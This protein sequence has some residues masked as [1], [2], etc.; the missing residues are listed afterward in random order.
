MG[1]LPHRSRSWFTV[2]VIAL[3]VSGVSRLSPGAA[4]GAVPTAAEQSEARISLAEHLADL[5]SQTVRSGGL[6]E[7]AFRE[8][9]VLLEAAGRVNPQEPRYPRLQASA[10]AQL[11]DLDG[12][13]G[14]WLAYRKLVPDDR[15]AQQ[16]LIDLYAAKI[17]TADGKLA[18]LRALLDK[19]QVPEEVRAHVGA[20]CVALLTDRSKDE[21]IEMTARAKKLYPLPEVL[22]WEYELVGKQAA[23][24]AR[25]HSLLALL[26]ANP[27]QPQRVAEL[28]HILASNGL[29]RESLDWYATALNLDNRIARAPSHNLAVEC[30]AELYI[31][32]ETQAAAS[33]VGRLLQVQPDDPDF[34]F[35]KLTLDRGAGQQVALSQNLGLAKDAFVRRLAVVNDQIL[36][37]NAGAATQAGV[38]DA[39]DPSAAIESLKAH[40]RPE[41]HDAF[42]WALDNLAWFEVYYDQQPDAATPWIKALKALLP[43]EDVT[44]RRV[45][46]WQ[47]LAAGR[48]AEARAAL[49]PVAEHDPLAAL[50]IIRLNKDI[51]DEAELEHF[52]A[53]KAKLLSD[54]PIGLLGAVLRE[55]LGVATP[56][57]QPA[58]TQPAST[59][60]TAASQTTGTTLPATP[61][62][63]PLATPLQPT[64]QSPDVDAIRAEL[65]KFPKD[66]L[67]VLEPTQHF[68]LLRAEPLKTSIHF[69]EPLFVRVS[70][71]NVGGR[72]LF[73]GPNGILQPHLWFNAQL[74]GIVTEASQGV[75]YDRIANVTVLRPGATATQIVRFDQGDLAEAMR[76]SPNGS[77]IVT[78][79]VITNP[80][81]LAGG[82][83]I[84]PGG[85]GVQF[86]K[87]FV[88]LPID[89]R[90]PIAQKK[91]EEALTNGSPADKFQAMTLLAHHVAMLQKEMDESARAATADLAKRIAA[92]RGDAL[93]EV[94]LWADY[95]LAA[96]PGLEGR[97]AKIR[98]MI[99]S[100]DW[101]ARLL[102]L[103]ALRG[104]HPEVQQNEASAVA[105]GDPDPAVKRFAAA[106]LDALK[107]PVI[108]PTTKPTEGPAASQPAATEPAGP[109]LPP[110]DSK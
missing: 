101:R 56:A 35:L 108:Q 30:A 90:S 80:V 84:G 110:T 70:L 107:H 66:W 53:A 77:V 102:G 109:A 1:C 39:P 7:P 99:A 87:N 62:T 85:S 26:Q 46:G 25:V 74:R 94:A 8:S 9:S 42:V 41:L 34:W 96:L 12:Q 93:P 88:R 64:V 45:Q 27:A 79:T 69:G 29:A 23:A 37:K 105:Q 98:E 6:G 13:I 81:P 28:A 33:V 22:G 95:L 86:S 71:K 50:G 72:D 68:Y 19:A 47:D 83:S 17:E 106:V 82:L 76:Q 44:L 24:P 4:A 18:Y 92:C 21:A 38:V 91:V 20:E 75:V 57:S 48:A 65:E 5:A 15:E 78:G 100:Q 51:K 3:A 11:Q 97:E 32:G 58:T 73:I 61:A 36:G 43:A 49:E 40:D 54:N 67:G 89:F 2:V 63:R 14:A 60:P 10:A 55:G 31:A 104:E 16:E 52:A 59:E 103:A